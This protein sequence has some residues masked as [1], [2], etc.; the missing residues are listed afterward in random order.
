[1][2][3]IEGVVFVAASGNLG[4]RD[5]LS[6]LLID[7]IL[8]IIQRD[9]SKKNILSYPASSAGEFPIIAVGATSAEGI[10]A[11]F[12]QG[13]PHLTVSAPGENVIC[14]SRNS[15]GYLRASGTSYA[16]PIVAGLAAYLMSLGKYHDRIYGGSVAQ[17]PYN[18]KKLIQELAYVRLGGTEPVVYNGWLAGSSSDVE[19]CSSLLGIGKRAANCCKFYL[20]LHLKSCLMLI[21]LFV[22]AIIAIESATSKPPA[23]L[24]STPP[25]PP[26]PPSL[27]PLPAPL[28]PPPP[29]PVSFEL[30]W[31][32][33][34]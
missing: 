12:S 25:P 20:F 34:D 13:G 31:N 7:C 21:Y 30:R 22:I 1:M 17:V 8:R 23:P 16:A 9:P 10:T 6:E 33:H 5:N 18:M 24:S 2:T 28:P 4:V 19:M 14:A 11:D 15:D 26:P 32:P 3:T 27:S 29:P